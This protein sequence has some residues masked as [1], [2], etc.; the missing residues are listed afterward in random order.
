MLNDDVTQ[1]VGHANPSGAI[2]SQVQL[3]E[4][5]YKHLAANFQVH[6]GRS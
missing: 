2:S 1:D 6:G 3:P 5:T 4:Y